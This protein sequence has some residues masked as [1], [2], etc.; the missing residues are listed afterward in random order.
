MTNPPNK[1]P[2]TPQTYQE[3]LAGII[4]EHTKEVLR[5]EA[6]PFGKNV[7]W[8]KA[9]NKAQAAINALNA[10][11]LKDEALFLSDVKPYQYNLVRRSPGA[12]KR[13]ALRA[14]LRKRFGEA[15]KGIL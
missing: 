6:D 8:V 7:D 13:N 3:R 12:V 2:V 15:E 14:D 11:I 4:T 1:P 9:G 5:V 10:E